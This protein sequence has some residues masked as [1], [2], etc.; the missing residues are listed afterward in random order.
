MAK[1][2]SKMDRSTGIPPE[3]DGVKR[4]SLMSEI[5]G[6]VGGGG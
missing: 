5:G 6:W 4:K 3:S 2:N 1:A